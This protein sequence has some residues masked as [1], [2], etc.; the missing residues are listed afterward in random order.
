MSSQAIVRN[1]TALS[2]QRLICQVRAQ[3]VEEHLPQAQLVFLEGLRGFDPRTDLAQPSSRH[4]AAQRD[5]S[6]QRFV[7]AGGIA[8]VAWTTRRTPAVRTLFWFLRGAKPLLS[9][10][11]FVLPPFQGLSL[12][13][14]HLNRAHIRWL[15][16]HVRTEFGHHRRLP[17]RACRRFTLG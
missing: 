1:N 10:F 15:Q 4:P 13:A 8:E 3:A 17:A 7:I 14:F 6:Q 16:S 11:R 9:A 12:R 5:Q 2:D